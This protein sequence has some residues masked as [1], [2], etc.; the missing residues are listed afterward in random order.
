MHLIKMTEMFINIFHDLIQ[1]K[2]NARYLF[3]AV[4][5]TASFIKINKRIIK[6]KTKNTVHNIKVDGPS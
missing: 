2:H 6:K 5:A 4:V 1:N 3:A